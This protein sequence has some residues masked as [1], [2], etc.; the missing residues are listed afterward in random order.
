MKINKIIVG[1]KEY[2]LKGT[3]NI[4]QMKIEIENG[5]GNDL[6]L[7]NSGFNGRCMKLLS[8]KNERLFL[9]CLNIDGKIKKTIY[10]IEYLVIGTYNEN[11]ISGIKEMKA[12]FSMPNKK[13]LS[14]E[15]NFLKQFIVDSSNIVITNE[16]ILLKGENREEI[17]LLDILENILQIICIIHG[18][19][20]EVK[21]IEYETLENNI[22]KYYKN[23]KS[24]TSIFDTMISDKIIDIGV[25]N[26][27]DNIYN[28][29]CKLK[30]KSRSMFIHSYLALQSNNTNFIDYKLANI[31]QVID[32]FFCEFY[33]KKVKK[34]Y[35]NERKNID[36]KIK[37]II[38]FSK[39]HLTKFKCKKEFIDSVCSSIGYVKKI[40]FRKY[41]EYI[42]Y[43][44]SFS[45][46]IFRDEFN[47]V[48]ENIGKISIDKMIEMSINERNKLS[49]MIISN[50]KNY[51]SKDELKTYYIKYKLLY[52]CIIAG[53]LG[54]IP[55]E[56]RVEKNS[57]IEKNR[58]MYR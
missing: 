46:I 11:S 49:H 19:Y 29:F 53:E 52:R 47:N 15:E 20:P 55:D 35:E 2:E 43:N 4:K 48:D 44:F 9:K 31:L 57:N 24:S 14:F 51:F 58:L 26:N 22:K 6:N 10:D 37:D 12:F 25:I 40:D 1:E 54:I 42:M 34:F 17:D 33:E 23:I 56:E 32:G 21:Y 3:L 7:V 5:I 39:D 50:N 16:Y 41:L 45:R 18:C 13:N 38:S 30:E 8:E 36:E 28:K 27:F